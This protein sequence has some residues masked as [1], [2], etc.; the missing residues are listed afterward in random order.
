MGSEGQ[1]GEHDTMIGHA[2]DTGGQGDSGGSHGQG[3]RGLS[4]PECLANRLKKQHVSATILFW[5]V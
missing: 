1:Q 4:D 2:K 5:I 3:V